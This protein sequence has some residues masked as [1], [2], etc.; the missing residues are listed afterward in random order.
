M[1]PEMMAQYGQQMSME[2]AEGVV[3][4]PGYLVSEVVQN[5]IVYFHKMINERNVYETQQIYD[6]GFN[7]N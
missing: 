6:E 2:G 3:P 1:D 5:F 4:L 7:I